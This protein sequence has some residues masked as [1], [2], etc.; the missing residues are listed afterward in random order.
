[1]AESWGD[2]SWTGDYIQFGRE[3]STGNQPRPFDL[4]RALCYKSGG[5]ASGPQD[6]ESMRIVAVVGLSE[7]GKT[8]LLAGLIAEF[9]RR[10]LRTFAVKHCAHGFSLDLEGKDTWTYTQAGADGVA[11]VSPEDWAVVRTL[12]RGRP[13]GPG[14]AGLPRRGRRPHRGREAG[15]GRPEDRGPEVRRLRPRPDAAGGAPG[16]RHRPRGA[17]G[18]GGAG[19]HAVAG[20][21]ALRPDPVARGGASCRRSSWRSTGRTSL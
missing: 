9:K 21:R 8:R 12:R 20:R 13:R 15:P 17:A 18:D 3:I 11:M 6:A 7:S 2:V 4:P 1:M 16:R 5:Y 10:G 19:L 14:R